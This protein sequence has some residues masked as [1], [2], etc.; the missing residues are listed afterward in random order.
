MIH[1]YRILLFSFIFSFLAVTGRLFYWQ[2]IKSPELKEKALSQTYK[3]EI[4]N[5]SRGQILA[6]DNFPR[7]Q[8]N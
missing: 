3:L 4:K 6:S 8:S 2:V 5:P 7:S 1:R